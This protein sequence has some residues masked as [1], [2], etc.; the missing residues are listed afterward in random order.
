[1][2][3]KKTSAPKADADP[4]T[5]SAAEDIDDQ[6]DANVESTAGETPDAPDTPPNDVAPEDRAATAPDPDTQEEVSAAEVLDPDAPD[7]TEKTD[8][9]AAQDEETPDETTSPHTETE[10]DTVLP[11]PVH[12][13]P[14]ETRKGGVFALLLGGILAG[15]IGFGAAYFGFF[16]RGDGTDTLHAEMTAGLQA[17]SNEIAGLTDRLDDIP[18]AQEL[19][20]FG[21]SLSDLTKA[22]DGLTGRVEELDT[23]L[24]DLDTRLTELEKRPMTE[25]ASDAAVAA[26]E[27]ELKALQDAMAAQRDEIGAMAQEAQDMENNA[28]ETARDTMRRAALTRIRTALDTGEGFAS[29]VDDLQQADVDVPAALT[30]VAKEGVPSQ[31]QLQES[32][33]GAA[34]AALSVSRRDAA[35]RGESGGFSTFVKNQLGTRSLEPREG[36]DPDA[37]LSRAEA[38]VREGRLSDALAEIEA[39][40][41]VGRVE[42]S[43]W[44]GQAQRRLDAIAASEALSQELN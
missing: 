3:K 9:G 27:R 16:Q 12:S 7:D 10:T 23:Q 41:E 31:A 20:A 26:Y 34:R 37:I 22:V 1:M 14:A 2:A 40:P 18:Q 28:A 11:I 8:A 43:Y 36:D 44:T 15:A 17:Q 38:A 42:L 21:T 13:D 32:F 5:V 30:D 19:S 24:S 29:A 4:D 25:A 35:Q 33:P 39:L 6:A